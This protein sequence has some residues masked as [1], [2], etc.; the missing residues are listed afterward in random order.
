MVKVKTRKTKG[1]NEQ[2][3]VV[4]KAQKKD[5]FKAKLAFW[6]SMGFWLP[7][8]NVGLSFAS[9]I[10]AL[11]ALKAIDKNPDFV[12]GRAYAII[13]LIIG[14]TSFAGSILFFAVYAYRR[15]TCDVVCT[16]F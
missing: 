10:L 11:K 7:L 3:K 5:F 12:G 14:I 13:A 6:L 2:S 16:I 4:V 1:I 15:I 8:F 9:I